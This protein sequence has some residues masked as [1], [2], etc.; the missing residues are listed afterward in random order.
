MPEVEVNG[1]RLFYQQSG[2]GPDV[3]LVHAVTSNQAVWVFSGLVEALAAD[4]RVT[5]YD[6]RGHGASARPATGYTSAVMAEDFRQFHAALGLKPAFLVGHS[7]GGVVSMHAA[8]VAPECVAGVLL[9]DSFFPGLKHIEPNF[10]K[11]GIWGDVRETFARVGV[12][13]GDTVDFTRLFR[14]TAALSPEK[15]KELEDIYGAFGRGWLRQL[16]RLAETTCGDEV[17]AEAGLTERV[18]AGITKPVVAL[19]DE[20]SPFLATC[21][22]LEQHLA[23]CVAEIIPAAKHLAMLDNTAGFTDA[24]K[25][26]LT[27]LS[28]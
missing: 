7:F 10:G 3:V 26:H 23:K 27:R 22:W 4:F 15:M 2:E 18:L 14:E 5:A 9:S 12:E 25:R 21:R 17:L 16:P 28:Q 8:V 13:L 24:V 6:M 1:T 20:F 11:M 19:Y